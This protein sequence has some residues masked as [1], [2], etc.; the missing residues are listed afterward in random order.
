MQD[1]FKETLYFQK[2]LIICFICKNI[3]NRPTKCNQCKNLFCFDCI[4]KYSE[5]LINNNNN[6]NDDNINNKKND[7]N[8]NDNKQNE[9]KITNFYCPNCKSEDFEF[10]NFL[11][12]FIEQYI[13][14]KCEKCGK[15][16]KNKEE[17]NHHLKNCKED[18]ICE[19]CE[20]ENYFVIEEDFFEHLMQKHLKNIEMFL[21]N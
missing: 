11:Y 3:L 2:N 6:N 9:K 8:N 12:K 16:F 1:N 15:E 7:N 21:K 17:L 10:Q 19:L 20:N 14:N 5:N 13:E 18:Y 4:K